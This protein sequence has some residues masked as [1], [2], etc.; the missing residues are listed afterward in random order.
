MFFSVF[1]YFF[2]FYHIMCF[3]IQSV[4]GDN[5][6]NLPSNRSGSVNVLYLREYMLIEDVTRKKNIRSV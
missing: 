3:E 1:F 4:W 6:H 5:P 2:L